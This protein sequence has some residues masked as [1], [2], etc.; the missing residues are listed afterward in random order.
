M[1]IKKLG[2]LLSPI[3]ETYELLIPQMNEQKKI[4]TLQDLGFDYKV[5]EYNPNFEA[6]KEL[7]ESDL[8]QRVLGE[9]KI[10]KMEELDRNIVEDIFH[11]GKGIK[12]LSLRKENQ[13]EPRY[14]LEI[15][16]S[17]GLIIESGGY[18]N[19]DYRL[20]KHFEIEPKTPLQ[21]I[22]RYE[23]NPEYIF[24]ESHLFEEQ[25]PFDILY[26]LYLQK[27]REWNP[28]F[29]DTIKS[30]AKGEIERRLNEKYEEKLKELYKNLQRE[31]DNFSGNDEIW[32]GVKINHYPKKDINGAI[33]GNIYFRP[34]ISSDSKDLKEVKLEDILSKFNEIEKYVRKV[35]SKIDFS[36]TTDKF[37]KS[38]YSSYYNQYKI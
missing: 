7:L 24:I 37:L 35:Y 26:S 34:F 9:G 27:E 29:I 12:K 8:A 13:Y 23:I 30:N 33:K 20:R 19:L 22:L 16:F 10:E 5:L 14:D 2:D 38:I 21:H 15:E 17:N 6:Q 36:K 1:K 25:I 3:K 4:I 31:M 11:L 32:F 28:E 18:P